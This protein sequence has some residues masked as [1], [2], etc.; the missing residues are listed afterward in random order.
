MVIAGFLPSTSSKFKLKYITKTQENWP[1]LSIWRKDILHLLYWEQVRK[2]QGHG[3]WHFSA[4][5]TLIREPVGP[6]PV[7]IPTWT[8]CE[9]WRRPIYLWKFSFIETIWKKNS[10]CNHNLKNSS[11]RNPWL[12]FYLCSRHVTTQS[13]FNPRSGRHGFLDP[14]LQMLGNGL[15][16]LPWWYFW[17]FRNPVTSWYCK[18][19][20]YLQSFMHLRWL[21]GISEP[22][23]VFFGI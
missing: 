13:T 14:M 1:N 7:D 17:C 18:Y 20:R 5:F 9:K 15:S 12:F 11:T 2:A 22:S 6:M 4:F 3:E 8:L 19:P 16:N 23:T 21:F 10:F